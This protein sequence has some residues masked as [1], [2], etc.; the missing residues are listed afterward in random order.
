LTFE[1]V[2]EA[3]ASRSLKWHDTPEK[4][5]SALELAGAMCGEAGEAANVAKKLKRLDVGMTQNRTKK[6]REGLVYGL[7]K[8]IADTFIYG[9]SLA[10]KENIDVA[11][12]IVRVF[13]EVSEA[14]GFPERL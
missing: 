7:G 11:A 9:F 6:S 3:C 14:E 1:R 13:N 12:C 5:W 10:R 8:E 4:Q 2:A